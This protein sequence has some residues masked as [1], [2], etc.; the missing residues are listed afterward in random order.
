MQTL[1]MEFNKLL[2]REHSTTLLGFE[3][4]PPS[5]NTHGT[6][7]YPK[8]LA[9]FPIIQTLCMEFDQLLVSEEASTAIGIG[10]ESDLLS[11]IKYRA[12]FYAQFSSYLC[13]V[14]A[15]FV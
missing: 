7:I 2:V 3:P 6:S 9:H 13:I 8:P 5:A 11:V 15:F 1:F 12:I 4:E 10:F 14:H